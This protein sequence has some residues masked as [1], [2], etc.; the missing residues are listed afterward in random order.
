MS[1]SS[2]RSTALRRYWRQVREVQRPTKADTRTARTAVRVLRSTR[3]LTSAHATRQH[4][5]IVSRIVKQSLDVA[6]PPTTG[7]P[8]RDLDDFIAAYEAWDYDY[9]VFD[10]E[11]S[12]DY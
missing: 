5:Q 2:A 8:Y 3:Q 9:D 11:T 10:V 12:A 4:K 1:R 7:K 6:P